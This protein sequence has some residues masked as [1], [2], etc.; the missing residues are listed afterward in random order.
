MNRKKHPTEG[1][2]VGFIDKERYSYAE[3][4]ENGNYHTMQS[5][6]SPK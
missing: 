2:K 5:H 4:F 3:H 6:L 1:S